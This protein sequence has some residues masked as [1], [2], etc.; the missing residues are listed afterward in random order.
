MLSASW[1]GGHVGANLIF[2]GGE[3]NGRKQIDRHCVWTAV[4]EVGLCPR[5]KIN[6]KKKFGKNTL[7]DR[8]P[9]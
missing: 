2:E 8:K 3:L 1:A 6:L 4:Y 9:D 7:L 5:E